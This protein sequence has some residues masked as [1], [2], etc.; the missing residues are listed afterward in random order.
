ML[1]FLSYV[2]QCMI[3]NSHLVLVGWQPVQ[4]KMQI[5]WEWHCAIGQVV[6]GILKDHFG[7]KFCL[8][9]GVKTL[10]SFRM[11]RITCPLRLYQIP[12]NSLFQQHCCKYFAS[13]DL[14]CCS[15]NIDS[16]SY[17]IALFPSCSILQRKRQKLVGNLTRP[18]TCREQYPNAVVQ[19][20]GLAYFGSG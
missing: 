4:L 6:L 2:V 11:P 1:W 16:V 19:G 14:S 12:E 5:F 3:L 8:T 7:F 17:L 10:W 13:H 9:Q 20:Q 18:L 15:R